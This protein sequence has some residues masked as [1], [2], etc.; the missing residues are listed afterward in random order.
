MRFRQVFHRVLE[1][2]ELRI[3]SRGLPLV[4]GCVSLLHGDRSMVLHGFDPVPGAGG[5]Q[6]E[7]FT[8]TGQL[9]YLFKDGRISLYSDL[10]LTD[11]DVGRYENLGNGRYR[12]VLHRDGVPDSNWIVRPGRVSWRHPPDGNLGMKRWGARLFYRPKNDSAEM[13]LLASAE[14]RDA[15]IKAAME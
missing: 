3:S 15:R 4:R 8:G 11:Y 9:N 2:S 6:R 7:C 12:V 10:H 13:K 5:D 14:S 1:I